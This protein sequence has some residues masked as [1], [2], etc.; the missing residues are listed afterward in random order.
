MLMSEPIIKKFTKFIVAECNQGQPKKGVETGGQFICDKFD[1]FPHFIIENNSF[2][3]VDSEIDNGYERLSTILEIYNKEKETTM[4]LGGDHSLG[5]SS[6]DAF[7]NIYKEELSVL[8]IDA[9]AD[10]N[11]HITSLSG[12]TH[13]MPLGYHHIKRTDKPAWRTN[14]QKLK[15]SQLYYWGI[16]DLDPTEEDLIKSENIGYSNTIDTNLMNFINKSKYLLISFDV[17]S[18][19]PKYMNSTG[20]MA[21]KGLIPIDVKTII[22]Y[23]FGTNKLIHLDVMEFNPLLGDIDKSVETLKEI[24]L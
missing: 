11:D 23:S 13:G 22:N 1:I 9:H 4:L 14:P 16:R 24:F 12:N 6:V 2:N 20:T 21:E 8:W 10:I 15:S 7:L 17:D 5:I 18:L 19:D 3:N